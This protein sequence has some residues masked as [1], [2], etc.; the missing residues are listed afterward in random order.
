MP[1]LQLV[2]QSCLFE[3]QHDVCDKTDTKSCTFCNQVSNNV[4]KTHQESLE[5][6]DDEVLPPSEELWS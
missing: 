5:D 2:Q 6:S 1:S 4:P 3:G